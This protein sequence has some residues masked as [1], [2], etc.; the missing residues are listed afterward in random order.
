MT[1]PLDYFDRYRDLVDDWPAFR[2]ALGTPLPTCLWA[3]TLRVSPAALAGRLSQELGAAPAPV[4]WYPGAFRWPEG[5]AESPG[6]T[7]AFAQGL[8]A[9]QEEAALL[10][11]LLLAPRPGERL[12]DLCAAPGN[13]TAQLAVALGRAGTVVANDFRWSRIAPL[14]RIL[15][16]LGILN[17]V[18]TAGN[19]ATF[20]A[21]PRHGPYDGVMVD[22]PCS[23]DATV[24]KSPKVVH[25]QDERRRRQTAGVQRALLRRALALCRPGGRVVY[26]TCSFAPEENEVV[27]SDVL[28]EPGGSVRARLRPVAVPGLRLASGV[29]RWAGVELHPDVPRHSVRLWPHHNDT[30]GFFVAVFDVLGEGSG[31]GAASPPSAGPRGGA[32]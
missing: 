21:D 20:A 8:Y 7:V 15:E 29:P 28:R 23:C 11:A 5:A 32:P 19:G 2:E 26:A 9:L 17:V 18:A 1:D 10:P 12:L 3:N 24:R 6:R 13:K 30:G 25:R 31:Q 16:R 22:V 4:P 27:V 14:R